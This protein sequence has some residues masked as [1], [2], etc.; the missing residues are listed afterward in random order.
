MKKNWIPKITI[1]G[2]LQREFQS[3]RQ[4]VKLTAFQSSAS[5]LSCIAFNRDFNKRLMRYGRLWVPDWSATRWPKYFMQTVDQRVGRVA[6][7]EQRMMSPASHAAV[8]MRRVSTNVRDIV[9]AFIIVRC[10][11]CQFIN[12]L[13]RKQWRHIEQLGCAWP[14]FRLS[15]YRLIH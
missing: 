8:T 12:L 3:V 10:A 13:I 14:N 7:Y 5:I 2:I 9:S 11:I 6:C 4:H 1:E 15:L